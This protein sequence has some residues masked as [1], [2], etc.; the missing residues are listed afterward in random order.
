MTFLVV[1]IAILSF[2]IVIF[3]YNMIAVFTLAV[4]CAIYYSF[5]KRIRRLRAFS[6]ILKKVK[7][8][9]GQFL[10]SHEKEIE[11]KNSVFDMEATPLSFRESLVLSGKDCKR[12]FIFS[13]ILFVVI[14][15]PFLLSGSVVVRE[16]L[17]GMH[18]GME[19]GQAMKQLIE[20]TPVWFFVCVVTGVCVALVVACFAFSLPVI[21]I[22]Y[23]IL[24]QRVKK[25]MNRLEKFAAAETKPINLKM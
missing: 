4:I 2:A 23:G 9:E 18:N 20:T 3:T 15:V 6:R 7:K 21:L 24:N 14:F 1:L 25:M 13:L 10:S 11:G 16:A 22:L 17:N 19:A 8:S 12:L 5:F